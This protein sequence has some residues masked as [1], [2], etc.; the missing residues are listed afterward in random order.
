MGIIAAEIECCRVTMDI[1][2]ELAMIKLL[3][4]EQSDTFGELSG[5]ISAVAGGREEQR[6]VEATVRLWLTKINRLVKRVELVDTGV[7]P[8]LLVLVLLSRIQPANGTLGPK[9]NQLLDLK[10]KHSS[11]QEAKNTLRLAEENAKQ[12]NLLFVFTG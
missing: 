5:W 9:I 6:K 10:L 3:I 12:S 8:R 2:D 11:L 1:K 7:G 4:E